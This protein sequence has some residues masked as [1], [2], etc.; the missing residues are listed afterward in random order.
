[1]F[2]FSLRE[3][4]LLTCV[5]GLCIGWGLDRARAARTSQ[6]RQRDWRTCALALGERLAKSTCE[7]FRLVT[8]DGNAFNFVGD[9]DK[10]NEREPLSLEWKKRE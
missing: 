2:R 5:V 7:N 10:L 9:G 4:L 8:P 6:A 1:M 3:L